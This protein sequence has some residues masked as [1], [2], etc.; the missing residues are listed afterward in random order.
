MLTSS[1]LLRNGL[2]T[3][4]P[5]KILRL[6]IAITAA[7]SLE[8]CHI[9][10]NTSVKDRNITFQNHI[11][12]TLHRRKLQFLSYMGAKISAHYLLVQDFVHIFVA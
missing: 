9:A 3:T 1:P 12:N 4:Y 10:L 8:I 2:Y 7:C 6:Q 5:E 11:S